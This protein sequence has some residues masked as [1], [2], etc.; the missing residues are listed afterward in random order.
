MRSANSVPATI[1][2]LLCLAA[3]ATPQTSP[4]STDI[5]LFTIEARPAGWAIEGHVPVTQRDGYDNQPQFSRDGTAIFYTSAR[6]G[7]TDIFR[8]D[9]QTLR[10]EAVLE[11]PESEYSPT[12]L[13]DGSGLAVVRVEADGTQRLWKLPPS[14][15]AP[16]L[17]VAD[18]E[19][20]GY[21]AW[22]DAK[23]VAVFVLGD[24]ATLQLVELGTPGA[25]KLAK[26]IGRSI[27]PV[28]GRIAVS[29][30]DKSRDEW[31]IEEVYLDAKRPRRVA[32]CVQGAEDYAWTPDGRLMMAANSEL[33]TRRPGESDWTLAHSFKELGLVDITRLAFSPDGQRLALVAKRGEPGSR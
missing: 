6:Q 13:P 20:V 8:Y 18:V 3:S 4:P 9:L 7:Q 30:V 10:R 12:P 31:W 21:H 29:F 25:R 26:G 1:L 19:P 33:Y 14:G 17:L 23:R 15:G 16:E 22:I 28:P 24:P 27:H 11:T 5:H 2:C 32:P